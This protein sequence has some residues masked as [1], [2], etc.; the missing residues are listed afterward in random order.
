[1]PPTLTED[2]RALLIT[3]DNVVALWQLSTAQRRSVMRAAKLGHWRRLSRGV[4]LGVPG[5][6]SADQLVWAARLYGGEHARLS[7]RTALSLHGWTQTL[8]TPHDVVVPHHIQRSD[9][10]DWVRTPRTGCGSTG[11]CNR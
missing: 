4:Y 11:S 8:Q 7:G 2:L 9:P 10:P 1:M 5:K 6:P 3:Q